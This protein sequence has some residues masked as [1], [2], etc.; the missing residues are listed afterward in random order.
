MTPK[1]KDWRRADWKELNFVGSIDWAVDLQEFTSTDLTPRRTGL[2]PETDP[3]RDYWNLTYHITDDLTISGTASRPAARNPV[4]TKSQ[5]S[6]RRPL[7]IFLKPWVLSQIPVRLGCDWSAEE[8]PICERQERRDSLRPL[9]VDLNR[10]CK[11]GCKYG[12]CPD[13]VC[14]SV[15][16]DSAT[17]SDDDDEPVTTGED[18][19][20]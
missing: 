16:A 20:Y 8:T 2:N 18:P 6:G 4:W 1:T 12:Y 3:N 15:A 19:N 13:D 5:G 11:F 17:S 10:L 7:R 9:D 14:T